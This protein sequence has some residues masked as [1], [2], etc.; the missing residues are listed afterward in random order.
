MNK[1]TNKVNKNKVIPVLQFK[2]LLKTQ[3][4]NTKQSQI[5]K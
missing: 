4:G 3:N 2:K 1:P 5:P